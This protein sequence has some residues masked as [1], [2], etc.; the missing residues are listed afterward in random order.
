M[1]PPE[2][3]EDYGHTYGSHSEMS[4][5]PEMIEDYRDTYPEVTGV[6][7]AD[8]TFVGFHGGI[9][10]RFGKAVMRL[11]LFLVMEHIIHPIMV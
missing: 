8:D 2:M 10:S 11:F 9:L 3:I 6:L 4:V 5:V 1:P 7:P